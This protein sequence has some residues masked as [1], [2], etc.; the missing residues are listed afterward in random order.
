MFSSPYGQCEITS[1]MRTIAEEFPEMVHD[2]IYKKEACEL[3][4]EHS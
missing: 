2:S 4:Q 1:S 3:V